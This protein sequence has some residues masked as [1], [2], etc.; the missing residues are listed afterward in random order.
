MEYS[1][2]EIM[3]YFITYSFLGWVMESIFRS[4]CERK[5]IN[6]GFL[7]GPF[8]P[9]YGVGAIIMLLFLKNFSNNILLLFVVSIIVLTIWEY[10]VGV[11]LEK[12]FHTKY[13][14][15]SNNK[16]NFQGRICLM[17]S[18]FWGILGVVFVKF[19]HLMIE[20]LISKI[21]IRILAFVYSI[22]AI[23]MIVD[24]IVSIIK[25]K[26]IKVT[27]EKIEKLNAEIKEKLKEISEE[28]IIK[29]DKTLLRLYKNVY[30]L[31]K[32]FPAINTK[33]ITEVL[34]K[35]VELK[36]IK[37]E[38]KEKIKMKKDKARKA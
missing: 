26:N 6:T 25:V 37:E 18:L 14:D 32:A 3:I 8:C 35:K 7:I 34:N 27:L 12:L 30:R 9:I 22:I 19:I 38:I 31:K 11:L 24:M 33:E 1:F 10:L 5:L 16:F 21:D 15:Y 4:I 36:E 17:N 23:V 28:T 29:R 2:L 20:N 13:W